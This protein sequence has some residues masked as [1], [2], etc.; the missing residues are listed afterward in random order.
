MKTEFAKRTGF[1]LSFILLAISI[2]ACP[3]RYLIAMEIKQPLINDSIK[4]VL[5]DHDD[6]IVATIQAKW[7]QHKYI[8]KTF[9][10]KDLSDDEI[11]VHWGKPLT[12][13]IRLLYETENIDMAMSYNIAT[14]KDFPKSLFDDSIKTLT[15]FRKAGLKVG[16]VTA[17]T[18]S[19]LENDFKTLNISKHLF[20]YIQTEDDTNYHKPDSRV[21]QP[22]IEWLAEQGIK[23][24]E[25]AYVGDSLKD[26]AAAV[27]A[28][29]HFIGV[30]TGLITLEEFEQQKA[31]AVKRLAELLPL[32]ERR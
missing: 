12:V 23:P 21:F 7:A 9:Y 17:T 20:D 8:A 5:F 14:R 31:A 30:C 4:V 28:G 2:F 1:S 27:G 26:M 18:L 29:F 10:D 22:T 15:S 6:T 16:L 24:S 13:L 3:L 11:R 19:S 25:V 32:A